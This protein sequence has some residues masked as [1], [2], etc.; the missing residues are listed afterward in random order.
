M[1]P[2]G[3]RTGHHCRVGNPIIYDTDISRIHDRWLDPPEDVEEG[4]PGDPDEA[5]DRMVDFENDKT[6]EA[7]DAR[8]DR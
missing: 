3:R 5:Y 4:D 6:K 1:V 2:C 7:H 8:N